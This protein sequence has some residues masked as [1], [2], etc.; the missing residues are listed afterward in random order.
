[1][2][3]I[4]MDQHMTHLAFRLLAATAL[5]LSLGACVMDPALTGGTGAATSATA[6]KTADLP[7]DA[8]LIEGVYSAKA[9]PQFTVPAVPVE[10]VPQEF[11]RQT[12]AYETDSLLAPSSSTPRPGIFILSPARTRPCVMASPLAG[13]GSNG[14]VRR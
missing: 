10:K 1:M 11:Q 3:K 9:D 4:R 14:R 13:R 7:K 2:A 5:S 8:K 6:V 12:V